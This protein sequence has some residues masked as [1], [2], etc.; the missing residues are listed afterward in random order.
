MT[1]DVLLDSTGDLPNSTVLGRGIDVIAQ[2]IRIRLNQHLGEW[3]ADV[4][5]GLPWIDWKQA[6][7]FPLVDASARIRI[8]VEQ[9]QGVVRVEDWT[10]SFDPATRRAT[11]S[12]TAIT[13]EGELSF[14]IN[15]Y[16]DQTDHNRSPWVAIEAVGSVIP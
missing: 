16:Q 14:V 6:K 5:K 15:P 13:D 2:M 8:E 4:R 9:T 11:F 3:F 12:G 10:E 7:P 1:I